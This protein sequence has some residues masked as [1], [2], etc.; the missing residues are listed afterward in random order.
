[1]DVHKKFTYQ[2]LSQ[3]RRIIYRNGSLYFA[4]I[5]YFDLFL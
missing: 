2:D 4:G 1:M 5:D 3:K